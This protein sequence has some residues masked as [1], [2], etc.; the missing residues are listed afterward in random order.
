M[1]IIGWHFK[2]EKYS[3]KCENPWTFLSLC[4]GGYRL[5]K[6]GLDILVLK[7]TVSWHAQNPLSE[8]LILILKMVDGLSK[9][10][11]VIA[12][13]GNTE[14]DCYNLPGWNKM[15]W[16]LTTSYMREA[17]EFSDFV[18]YH[19]GWKTLENVHRTSLAMVTETPQNHT[20]N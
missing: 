12:K 5:I 19:S 13:T 14:Y 7:W 2:A 15:L 20:H 6:T 16:Q 17:D 8:V 10:E 1:I 18:V 9:E 11:R 3:A 4:I